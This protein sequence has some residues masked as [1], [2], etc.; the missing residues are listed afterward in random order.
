MEPISEEALSLARII[1]DYHQLRHEPIPAD[2]IV[3]LGT[4]DL[5]VADFAADLFQRGFGSTL[6]C[7]GGV[8][9]QDDLLATRWE[10]TEAEM[11]ADAAE[12]RGVPRERILVE[13][14]AS[15]TAENIRFTRELLDKRQ[16]RPR[17]IVLA[18]KPFMQRRVWATMAVEWPEMPATLASPEM[19]LDQYFTSELAPEKIVNIMMGDLQRTWVYARRG[20]SAPQRL[21][22]EVREAYLG[23]VA[24]GFTKHLIAEE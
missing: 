18:V 5:R 14:R 2:V 23:L 6:V 9:H 22:A 11:Y 17:N 20:W 15:N 3:A 1:W 7:S 8:A 13:T 19:T 16:M 4:N 21:T 24:L 12:R 10:K